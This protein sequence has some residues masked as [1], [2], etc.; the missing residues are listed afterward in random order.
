MINLHTHARFNRCKWRYCFRKMIACTSELTLDWRP[1]LEVQ[2]SFG[3]NFVLQTLQVWSITCEFS[4][5]DVLYERMASLPKRLFLFSITFLQLVR[6][7]QFRTILVVTFLFETILKSKNKDW[8]TTVNE[9]GWMNRY[10]QFKSDFGC[11]WQWE[12]VIGCC[13]VQ[14]IVHT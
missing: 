14:K 6:V 2:Q 10:K 12:H 13:K 8:M 7:F 3:F 1:I 5:H 9:W 11:L 4:E